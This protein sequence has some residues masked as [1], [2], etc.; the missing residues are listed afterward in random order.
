MKLIRNIV[1]AFKRPLTSAIS[2]GE[3]ALNLVSRDIFTKDGEGVIVEMPGFMKPVDSLAEMLELPAKTGATCL[4]RDALR[5]GTFIYDETKA[6][7]NDGGVVFD[8][9]VRRYTKEVDVF[10]FGAVGNGIADDS[11]AIQAAFNTSSSGVI[12]SG[13]DLNFKI[14]NDITVLSKG[15]PHT[16]SFVLNFTGSIFSGSGRIIFDS[17]KKLHIEGVQILS[18]SLDLR[19]VWESTFLNCKASEIILSQTEG[20]EFS[21]CYW[22][23]FD[24]CTFQTLILGGALYGYTNSNLFLNCVFTAHVGVGFTLEKDYNIILEA[25]ASSQMLN[26]VNG[27]FSYAKEKILKIDTDKDVEISFTGSYFDSGTPYTDTLLSNQRVSVS[28]CHVGGKFRHD[29]PLV[30]ALKT[31]H[32]Y[33]GTVAEFNTSNY[34][35]VNFIRNG[36]LKKK[37]TEYRTTEGGFIQSTTATISDV[38]INDKVSYIKMTTPASS[39][40]NSYFASVPLPFEGRYTFVLIARLVGETEKELNFS[41]GGQYYNYTLK[42]EWMVI[43]LSPTASLAQ[44]TVY[45][46][47]MRTVDKSAFTVDIKYVGVNAGADGIMFAPESHLCQDNMASGTFVSSDNKTVTVIDGLIKTIV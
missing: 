25:G 35:P 23:K 4:W 30:E 26:F 6:S 15:R 29:L 24:T 20:V 21:P 5:G 33:V 45:N 46:I 44:D 36:S 13:Y 42:N 9:W 27:D 32:N 2:E 8:G 11:A 16:K 43:S 12:C 18:N 17:C 34:V 22:N 10:W 47:L 3:L 19:G 41:F 7:E 28:H 37:M 31:P 14:D 39:N 40:T 38:V 1:S